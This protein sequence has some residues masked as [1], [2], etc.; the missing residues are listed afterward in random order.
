MIKKRSES[1]MFAFSETMHYFVNSFR[2]KSTQQC[3]VL[4]TF[5]TSKH[6]DV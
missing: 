2:V 3:S 5:S 4:E 6:E 1:Q